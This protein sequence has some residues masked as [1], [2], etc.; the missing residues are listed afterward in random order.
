MRGIEGRQFLG[1]VAD[2]GDALGFQVFQRQA[3]V[4]NALGPRAYHQHLG[5]RQL[6]QVGG[7][8][9]GGF[10][11]AMNAAYAARGKD[12]DARQCGADHGG[13]H[14]GG[15]ILA[16]GEQDRQVTAAGL[17]HRQA[18]FAQMLDLFMGA[19]HGDL[20][21]NDGNRRGYRAV[22]TH[23]PLHVQGSFHILRVGHAM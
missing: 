17:G 20:A 3:Q 11:T 16:A 7:D 13:G 14:G 21:L 22:F 5:L 10:R 19:A 15:A 12:A 2:D 23:D 1:A 6:L 4:Q 8:V 18:L 9:H